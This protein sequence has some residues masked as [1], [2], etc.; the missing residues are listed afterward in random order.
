[1]CYFLSACILPVSLPFFPCQLSFSIVIS[2]SNF[3]ICA[4]VWVR[5]CVVCKMQHLHSLQI[6]M[7][8]P[9]VPDWGRTVVVHMSYELTSWLASPIFHSPFYHLLADLSVFL[10]CHPGPMVKGSTA[11][12]S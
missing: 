2:L 12:V 9:I 8:A 4:Q 10:L 11:L 1:M 5:A 7:Y 3:N 6:C